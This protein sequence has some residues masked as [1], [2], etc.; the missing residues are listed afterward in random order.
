MGIIKA[1][2]LTYDYIKR[3]EEGNP[4]GV[5]RAVDHVD[6]DIEAG[7]F[8]AVLGH[9]GSGKSTLA[10]HMNALLLPTE[11][12]IFIG[13]KDTSDEDN[14]WDVRKTAG[15]VFQNPDNQII[16]TVV[17][18]DVGFGPENIGVP[19][20]EIWKR[21][22]ESLKAVGMTA[23]RYHSPNKLSGGQK[24]RVAIAGV[25]AMRPKCIVLDEPTAMLDPNGRKEVLRTVREL[26]RKEHITVVLITHYMEEV[27]E[28]DRVFVMDDGRIVMEGTPQEV[29]G[30]TQEMK[31]YRLDVPQVTELSWELK[32]D[33]LP[34]SDGILTI[35][36][37]V[38]EIME[39]Y[40]G[41]NGRGD[42]G[43]VEAPGMETAQR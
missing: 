23:Y 30:R 8:V 4:D 21:V 10:K 36:Q 5:K 38:D 19:T 1:I 24:Q 40:N 2:K 35:D 39:L 22:D 6:I 12:T 16:G 26:N 41:G 17:E 34:L 25:M 37:F 3:D 15:M 31:D 20:E 29:F 32:Q 28:A 33:G 18:E 14:L 7:E 42:A 9:N 13:E 43:A 27:I 11:G